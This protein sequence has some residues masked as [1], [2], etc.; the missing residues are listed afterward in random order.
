MSIPFAKPYFSPRAR[1]E[2]LLAM[3]KIL[4]S[5]RMMLGEYAEKLESE[6]AAYIGTANAVTTNTCTTALNIVLMHYDVRDHEVLVPSAAFITD[7]SVVRWAGG[8][9][10]L[11]DT[12]PSTLSFDLDDLRH[13]LTSRTKGIIWVHLTG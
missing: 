2:I 9:P 1:R 8:N 4:A 10:V 12:D 13:K 7:V 3:D 6:F 11:V 5:G